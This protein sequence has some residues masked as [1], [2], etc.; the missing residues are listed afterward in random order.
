[1]KRLN[2][3]ILVVGATFIIAFATTSLVTNKGVEKIS[4]GKLSPVANCEV[5]LVELDLSPKKD[6]SKYICATEN[7]YN[8][9]KTA[10]RN[11]ANDK[12]KSYD[13]DINSR[14]ILAAVLNEEKQ[15]KGVAFPAKITK[16]EVRK[17]YLLLLE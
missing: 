8:D 16:E 3:T 5:G 6:N 14:E 9:I 10:L 17:Q 15:R 4:S 1:M 7:Q 13:F 12:S 11:E 2:N